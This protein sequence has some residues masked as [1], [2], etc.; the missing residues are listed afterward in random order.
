MRQLRHSQNFIK[1]GK[2]IE[3]LLKKTD[4]R[5]S[6]TVLEIGTGRGTI[7]EHLCKSTKRVISIEKD[8]RLYEF[9]SIKLRKFTNVKLIN[10]DFLD[11]SLPRY[12]YK[13]FSNIPFNYT[14][15]IIRKLLLHYKGPESAYLF[16]QKESAERFLGIGK[17]TQIS[18]LLAP[19]YD[20]KIIHT[21]KNYDFSPAP[22]VDVVLTA[23]NKRLPSD[24]MKRNYHMYVDF[25][26]FSFNQWKSDIGKS[27]KKLF[28]YKQLRK[29]SKGLDFS[30]I[31]KPSE[32]NYKQWLV[33][34]KF[35]LDNK[36]Q[37][38]Q[39]SFNSYSQFY[40]NKHRNQVS[41]HGS[42]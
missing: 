35:L 32:L 7:T 41:R 28:T 10:Q 37:I 39:R 9:S 21:F 38:S 8:Q 34:F 15:D 12:S 6:D 14:A 17:T 13:C 27:L 20:S 40:R 30:L 16:M 1:S 3:K 36:N 2:L 25:I 33:L 24:I 42:I 31:A 29:L 22:S 4:I 18:L 19:L 11:Y 23:F 26:T 5:S